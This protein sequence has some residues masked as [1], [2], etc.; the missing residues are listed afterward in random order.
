MKLFYGG[1]CAET[2]ENKPSYSTS[3]TDG[4]YLIR[5]GTFPFAGKDFPYEVIYKKVNGEY[6]VYHDEYEF[7]SS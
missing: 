5:R 2:P 6:L 7:P 1:D 3:S 4:E